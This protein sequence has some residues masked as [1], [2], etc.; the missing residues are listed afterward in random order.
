MTGR[1][2]GSSSSPEQT[3]GREN[4]TSVKMLTNSPPRPEAPLPTEHVFVCVGP[5][6]DGSRPCLATFHTKNEQV[7]K[8]TKNEQA[9]SGFPKLNLYT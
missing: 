4:C 2:S 7:Q 1:N 8:I 3:A 9:A 5:T 6:V